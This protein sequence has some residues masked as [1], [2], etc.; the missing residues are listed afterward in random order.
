[1]RTSVLLLT[2][3]FNLCLLI[4]ACGG[5]GGTNTPPPS[6]PS[7]TISASSDSVSL[8]HSVTLTWSSTNADS[9]EASATPSEADWT[10]SMATSG[11]QSVQATAAGSVAYTLS[12]MGAGGS[13]SHSAAVTWNVAQLAITSGAPVSGTVSIPYDVHDCGNHTN[14]SGFPL[15]ASGGVAPYGWS[16]APAQGSS[17]PPG[18]N[19]RASTHDTCPDSSGGTG[20]IAICGTP[21]TVGTYNVIVKVADS[22][23]PADSASANYSIVIRNPNPPTINSTITPSAGAVNLPYSFSFRAFD[24]LLPLSWSETGALP[25]GLALAPNGVL[26]GTPT[27]TGDFPIMVDVTDSL[28]RAAAPVGFTVQIFL[29]GFASTGSMT[30]TRVALLATLLCDLSAGQCNDIK[31][32]VTGESDPSAE[33]YDPASGT[34]AATGNLGISRNGYTATLLKNGKVLIAGGVDANSMK[35]ATAELYNPASGTFVPTGSM[36]TARAFH[37]AALLGSGKVL[38]TAGQGA[39]GAALAT[40]ELYDPANGTFAPTGSL[41]TARTSPVASPL[42]GGSVLIAGGVDAGGNTLATAELYNPASATF[43]STGS[44]EVARAGL[45]ATL[46]KNGDVLMTGG[47]D[48]SAELYDPGAGSFSATG[49]MS[50]ARVLHTATLLPD[51]TVLI[52]GGEG[53]NGGMITAELFDPASGT[54]SPTGSMTIARAQ[55]SATLLSTGKV[56]VAGGHDDELNALA[57]AELYQ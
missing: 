51:G 33:L 9:C 21:T 38:V 15:T 13:A 55:H 24:G 54:F 46:L 37:T 50:T 45:V 31:V 52:A 41:G 14:C 35:L 4:G 57:T 6:Q 53:N 1:M 56:L 36:G 16:W 11:S 49:S 47:F 12:C 10:G 40:A 43:A 28:G 30:T 23:S 3:T 39:D 29:H 32:L 42:N 27:A 34:F 17:L 44:M 18:L 26:S 7:V 5:A 48:N 19:I 2:F 8:G 25:P 20:F 22:A